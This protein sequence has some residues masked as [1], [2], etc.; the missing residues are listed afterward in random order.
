MS[1]EKLPTGYKRYH[2]GTIMKPRNI[3]VLLN[4]EDVR[5]VQKAIGGN[6][7]NAENHLA[8]Y[9]AFTMATEETLWMDEDGDFTAYDYTYDGVENGDVEIGN[10]IHIIGAK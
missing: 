3:K 1:N 4:L 7:R 6:L 10:A 9:Y 2:D 8:N 5:K